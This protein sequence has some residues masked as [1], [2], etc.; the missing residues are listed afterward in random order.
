VD[1]VT[2]LVEIKPEGDSVRMMFR[3]PEALK[4]YIAPKGSV[5]LD[6]VSLTVNEVEDDLFGINVIP[7]TQDATTLGQRSVGESLNLEIDML[8]R[9]VERMMKGN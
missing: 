3:A 1:G 8:A 9:Y 2:E 7:H 5:T 6:G 4:K